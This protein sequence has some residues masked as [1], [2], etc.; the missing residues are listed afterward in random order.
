MMDLNRQI[1]SVCAQDFILALKCRSAK[2]PERRKNVEA[3][4]VAPG[5]APHFLALVDI[6]LICFLFF[7]PKVSA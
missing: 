1:S 7:A 4:F 3:S 5:I 6:V 2:D